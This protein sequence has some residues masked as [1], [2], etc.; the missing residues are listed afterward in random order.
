MVEAIKGFSVSIVSR[1]NTAV[2]LGANVAREFFR[3]LRLRRPTGPEVLESNLLKGLLL[4][5][6]K[7][8]LNPSL[9]DLDPFVCVLRD[10][11]ALKRIYGYKDRITRLVAGP[12]FTAAE[13]LEIHQKFPDIRSFLAPS[14]EVKAAFKLHG[15]PEEKIIIWPVGIDTIKFDDTAKNNKTVDALIYF[16]RRT[17]EE[18]VQA[19]ALLSRLGKSF[20]VLPYGHYSEAEFLRALSVC[21]FAVIL[22]GTESQGIALQEIMSA[23]LPLFV[24][25]QIYVG[26]SPNEYFREN[27]KVTSVPYW[28][29]MCG[30]KVPTD[31]YGMSKNHYLTIPESA[32]DFERFLAGLI[33]F[34]PREFILQNLSLE[35]QAK[36]F[37]NL[38]YEPT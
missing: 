31:M 1:D 22:D 29:E 6:N 33:N 26:E 16:K 5:S 13:F 15:I 10:M 11:R 12:N 32:S 3:I 35:K 25:D 9:K 7:Y 30:I 20:I 27:L 37:V 18:L 24:F 2:G 36:E 8:K 34:K 28:A 21:R 23:N 4:T 38:M 14:P 17:E 19:K